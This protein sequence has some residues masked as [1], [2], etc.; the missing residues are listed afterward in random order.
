[1]A[2][3]GPEQRRGGRLPRFAFA[4]QGAW[5]AGPPSKAR[6]GRRR[7]PEVPSCSGPDG[8]GSSRA[9]NSRKELVR[10]AEA[11]R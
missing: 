9:K 6:A 8:Q 3:V 10:R 1:M 2:G 5:D 4:A 11:A 7:C